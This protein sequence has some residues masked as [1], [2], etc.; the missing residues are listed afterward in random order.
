[1]E[2]AGYGGSTARPSRTVADVVPD[3]EAI[4]DALGIERCATWGISGG[5]PHA[6]ACAALLPERVAA[7]AT[8]ASVAPYE[9]DGLDWL[10][11]MGEGNHV[12]FGA[13]KEGGETLER[14]LTEERD[15][16][17]AAGA[18]GLA[19]AMRPHRSPV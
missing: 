10:E 2:R 3:A 8:L 1:F 4:L 15:D 5:G 16:M 12:E 14:L 6:L 17:V 7:V 11:G 13:A 18:D 19:E 9:A